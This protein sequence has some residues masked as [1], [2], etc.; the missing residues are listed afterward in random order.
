MHV[1]SKRLIEFIRYFENMALN[2]KCFF[3][4]SN[5]YFMV[6][7]VNFT[8]FLLYFPNKMNETSLI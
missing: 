5:T 4:E 7:N 1:I 3:L 6:I 8:Y 2:M